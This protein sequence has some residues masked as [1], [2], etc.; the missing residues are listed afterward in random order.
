MENQE[1]A[2]VAARARARCVVITGASSGIGR[3]SALLMARKGFE[4]FAGV[5]RKAD[6][7]KLV[8]EGGSQI[9]P[10]MIDVTDDASIQSAAREVGAR[11]G[12]R[13]LYGL[14]NVAGIGTSGP[15]EFVTQN[16]LRRIFDVNVFGQIAAIQAFMPLILKSRGRI[17]NISSVGAHIAIPFGGALTASKAAFGLVSDSL[18]MEVSRFGVTVSVIEPGAIRTPAVDK[19]LGDVEGVIAGLPP[20]GVRRYGELLRRF[21]KHAH[22]RESSGSE[23]EVVARAIRHA[24]TARRPRTRYVVGKDSGKL[25]LLPV[26]LPDRILDWLRIKMLGLGD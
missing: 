8:E 11:L 22:A 19:T 7:R 13:G 5:R 6:A 10:V 4:V 23:P 15:V 1:A 21:T 3:A 17:V 24:L 14:V 25:A 12:D 9:S 16:E 2:G 18:R 26:L 20:E